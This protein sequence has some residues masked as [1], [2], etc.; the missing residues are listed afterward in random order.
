MPNPA[1]RQHPPS[2]R[3]PQRQGLVPGSQICP[4]DHHENSN[5]LDRGQR[6]TQED[7][8]DQKRERIEYR[9][10]PRDVGFPANG[11]GLEEPERSLEQSNSHHHN[12][13]YRESV[14]RRECDKHQRNTYLH[15]RRRRFERDCTTDVP[16]QNPLLGDRHGGESNGA[17]QRKGNPIH[18]VLLPF[19]PRLKLSCDHL[20][21]LAD[22]GV[23]DG[24]VGQHGDPSDQSKVFVRKESGTALGSGWADELNDS[25]AR[26]LR[27]GTPLRLDATL[28][29]YFPTVRSCSGAVRFCTGLSPLTSILTMRH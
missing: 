10:D 4:A 18:W 1:Q 21:Y 23:V 29:G 6:L 16:A 11:V 19:Y 7:D 9:H 2:R 26:S 25:N 20:Q 22:P 5:P 8:E 17:N 14:G 12:N 27:S 24:L 15:D 3:R 13:R 28:I